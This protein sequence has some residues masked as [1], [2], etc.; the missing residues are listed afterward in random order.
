RRDARRDRAR[1]APHGG[2]AAR[3]AVR[4][5]RAAGPA[6]VRRRVM[7]EA[8][9]SSAAIT[10]R[11]AEARVEDIARAVARLA[12][13]DLERIGARP[14]DTLQIRGRTIAVARAESGGAADEGFVQIDGTLRSNCGAGLE[15]QVSA[16]RVESGHAVA[17]RLTPLAAGTAPA[18]IAVERI[19]DDLQGVPVVNG[20]A[21]RVPTFAKAVNF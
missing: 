5:L 15:E 8:A 1:R 2:A 12:P 3:R 18:S 9:T 4:A 19:L 10:L 13:R 11:V 7:T 21:V 16:S 20:T 6:P 17:V 14:G